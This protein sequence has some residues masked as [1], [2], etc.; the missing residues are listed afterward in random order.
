MSSREFALTSA[1]GVAINCF[2]WRAQHPRAIVVIAHGA[3]EH[4]ARYA[5]FAQ[6]LNARGYEVFAED[7]R[8]HG[9]T[10]AAIAGLGNMGPANA[11]EHVV[12]DMIHLTSHA[13]SEFPGMPVILFGHSMG[14]L[15]AQRVLATQGELYRAA[16]LCGSLSVDVLAPAKPM[17]DDAVRQVGRDASAE[18]LQGAMFA[19]LMQG[20]ANPRTPF[21][22]LSRDAQEVDKYI[23]DPC[24]GFALTLGSWQDVAQ[25]AARTADPQELQ[26]IPRRLRVLIMSGAA[27]PVHLG[28]LGLQQLDARLAA[29]GLRHRDLRTYD[30]ARHEL[31]NETNR[32]DVIRD[33]IDWMDAALAARD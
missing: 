14:S 19:S 16:V 28:G 3:A 12:G 6:A 8:G 24:C 25:S 7:H 9:V 32:Q 26:R 31:L 5:H 2:H 18:A 4:G 21:D 20:F 27:D 11:L 29:A 33:T 17:I 22:W 30:G 15:I 23:A 1:D 13:R 10:A